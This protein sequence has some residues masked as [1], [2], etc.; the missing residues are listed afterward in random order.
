MLWAVIV[1]GKTA[2]PKYF[3]VDDRETGVESAERINAWVADMHDRHPDL[4]LDL[5]AEVIEWPD[6]PE[7]HAAILEE[8]RQREN[9]WEAVE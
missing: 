7:T 4:G 1:S 6:G 9:E 2:P 8:L 3:P 5:T